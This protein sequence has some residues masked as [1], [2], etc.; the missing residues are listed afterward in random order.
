MDELT[1]I[2]RHKAMVSFSKDHH[3]ALLLVWKIRQGLKKNIDAKRIS[4]Y[5]EFFFNEDLIKHFTDEETLLFIYLPEDD[6][7]R[8]TAEADHQN[9]YRIVKAIQE[10]NSSSSLL[11][12]LADALEQH[13][14]FEERTL[15]NQLQKNIGI[16]AMEVIE[17]RLS[18]GDGNLDAKWDD[19]FWI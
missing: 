6:P 18:P 9:I 1:P 19:H 3:F 17:K 12:E 4:K 10:N 5:V 16:E 8:K 2:K 7:L 14:R 13:I 15:F 11:L